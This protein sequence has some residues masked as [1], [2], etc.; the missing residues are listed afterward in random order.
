MFN[1][2]L[3]LWPVL[4]AAGLL[5][6]WRNLQQCMCRIIILRFEEK[7]VHVA[8]SPIPSLL[9]S[10]LSCTLIIIGL[11]L[12]IKKIPTPLQ[13]W[14]TENL[15]KNIYWAA[16]VQIS[17]FIYLSAIYI[18][19]RSVCLFGCSKICRPIV[20]IYKS[21]TCMNVENETEAAQSDFWEYIN[22]IF[23]AVC[24]WVEPHF[25]FRMGHSAVPPFRATFRLS[26]ATIHPTLMSCIPF[27]WPP[28]ISWTIEFVSCHTSPLSSYCTEDVAFHKLHP[29]AL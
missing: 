17:T 28:T 1:I 18:I 12:P 14:S 10:I 20:G 5:A 3:C 22:R 29:I 8:T 24:A 19:P 9:N 13:R 15:K 11:N 21:L 27:F 26:W 16:S 6:K 7:I 25:H 2:W 4:H 23:F